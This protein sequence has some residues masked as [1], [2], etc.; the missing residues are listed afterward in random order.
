[1]ASAGWVR[2]RLR[3]AV[4]AYD[5]GQFRTVV[6][7]G[8]G[9][10]A[11]MVELLRMYPRPGGIVFDV[12]RLGEGARQMINAAGLMARCQF[13]AGNAFEAVPAGGDAYV[14][15][16]FVI[17]WPDHEA[18]VPLR[19]CRKSIAPDGELLL[20]EWIMPSGDEPKEG[21]RFWDTVTMDLVMLTVFGSGGGHVRTRCLS[22]F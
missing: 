21:L 4:E 6:D 16:N 12:P 9:N 8:G 3:S 10:G 15:S 11:L 1:M 18:I 13:Q 17:N 20:G 14:L 19:N 7:V 2:Y 5:F 22:G